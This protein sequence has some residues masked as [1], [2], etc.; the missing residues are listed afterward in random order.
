VIIKIKEDS[1]VVLKKIRESERRQF[2]CVDSIVLRK[3][4]LI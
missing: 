2:V 3:V 1:K 4:F